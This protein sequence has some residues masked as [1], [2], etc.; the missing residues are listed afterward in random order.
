MHIQTRHTFVV[1]EKY[2]KLM[3]I[4]YYD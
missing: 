3:L 4:L 2:V 1:R